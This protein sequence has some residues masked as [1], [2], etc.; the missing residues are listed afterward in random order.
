[1]TWKKATDAARD[2]CG[3]ISP[4]ALYA[5]VKTG[6][7][8]AARV[9]ITGKRN[10]LFCESWCDEWLKS[11]ATVQQPSGTSAPLKMH[12]PGAA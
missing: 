5:A 10:L 3:G 9:G 7:L 6:Q 11:S 2:W 4:K 12:R 8:K 1:V